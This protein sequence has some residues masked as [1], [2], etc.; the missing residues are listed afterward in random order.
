[1]T[2]LFLADE[3][4]I[5]DSQPR[6]LVQIQQSKNV[7][8]YLATGQQ[9]IAWNGKTWIASPA[10]RTNIGVSTAGQDSTP[11]LTLALTHPFCQR[12][13]KLATPPQLCTVTIFRK[14][15][16][17]GAVEQI[18]FGYVTAITFDS[19]GAT[20]NQG[21]SQGG[22]A[23]HVAKFTL[24]QQLTRA[25]RRSLPCV[26]VSATVCPHVLYDKQCTIDPTSFTTTTTITALNG[27][28]VD[29]AA[30]FTDPAYLMNGDIQ[31][32]TTG[33][34]M[35]IGAQV[36]GV[37]DT[38]L[39]LQMPLPDAQIGDSVIVRA[40]CDHS[41]STCLAKFANNPNFGG[42]PGKQAAN[43]WASGA[44]SITVINTAA[45]NL[46]TTIIAPTASGTL[47]EWSPPGFI[48]VDGGTVTY[49][50]TI[51][52]TLTGDATLTGLGLQLTGAI[53]SIINETTAAHT[54]T[55]ANNSSGSTSAYRIFTLTGADMVLPNGG[56]IVL[57][58]STTL[59]G[60]A[61]TSF[62]A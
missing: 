59:G 47:D 1:M 25:L 45:A 40:G 62:T 22:G 6:E 4:S 20:V 7:I 30:T 35:T 44:S 55:I 10:T 49:A 41:V 8:Y 38:S 46:G 54:F 37:G 34:M 43:P 42:F 13:V 61:M 21:G 51:Q 14:Q 19:D 50:S 39:T 28:V 16:R 32:V 60:W 33:E 36:Q 11:T 5:E 3:A 12:Y 17:S 9:D 48:T 27:N 53:V 58:Y 29:I 31:H 23:G 57:A 24:S 18:F 15:L 26:P 2:D 52:V 56:S